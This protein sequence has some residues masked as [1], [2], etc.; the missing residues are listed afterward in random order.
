VTRKPVAEVGAGARQ[1]SNQR[2][3]AIGAWYL[4]RLAERER[5]E[6][7]LRPSETAA[8]LSLGT[9]DKDGDDSGAPETGIVIYTDPAVEE[10]KQL[11][12]A[13]RSRLAEVEAQ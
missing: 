3:T 4:A 1:A 13:A 9:R 8:L 11:I 5:R 2:S 6:V 12:D 7:A 10:L